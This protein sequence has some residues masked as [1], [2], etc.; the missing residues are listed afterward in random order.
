MIKTTLSLLLI[1]CLLFFPFIPFYSLKQKFCFYFFLLLTY[2]SPFVLAGKFVNYF[3]SK[4]EVCLLRPRE[5]EDNSRHSTSFQTSFFVQVFLEVTFSTLLF[6]STTTAKWTLMHPLPLRLCFTDFSLVTL[7]KK[8]EKQGRFQ[9][10]FRSQVVTWG[11]TKISYL[12]TQV[13]SLNLDKLKGVSRLPSWSNDR[14]HTVS[15]DYSSRQLQVSVYLCLWWYKDYCNNNQMRTWSKT[16]Q[17]REASF[18]ANMRRRKPRKKE[19][20]LCRLVF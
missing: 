7:L 15:R 17:Q 4:F 13:R 10:C 11:I 14:W 9:D 6:W 16:K 12:L 3:L 18:T 5:R 2:V 8:R 1:I 20:V 19:D